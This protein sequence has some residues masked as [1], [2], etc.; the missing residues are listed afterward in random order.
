M[1]SYLE[2]K[3]YFLREENKIKEKKAKTNNALYAMKFSPFKNGK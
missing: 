3:T 2:I 1:Q